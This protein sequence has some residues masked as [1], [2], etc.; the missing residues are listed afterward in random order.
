MAILPGQ[1]LEK[2]L[3]VIAKLRSPGGCPWD[4]EQTH[5]SLKPYLV[6]ESY[7]VLDAI[8]GQEP[9]VLKDELGDL[10]LQVVLHAQ[11]AQEKGDFTFAE[12]AENIREKMVRRHP[13]V[14]SDTKVDGV[15]QVWTNWEKIKKTEKDNHKKSILDSIPAS[16]PA[17]FRASKIQKKAARV[18]FDW[19]DEQGVIDKLQEEIN[20]LRAIKNQ[21]ELA[22]EFGDI[23]F[24]LVNFARK[25]DLDAEDTLRLATKKFEARFRKIEKIAQAAGKDLSEYSLTELDQLWQKAKK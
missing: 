8:D 18:G 9:A 16:L 25:K 23:L 24:T 4:K 22:D 14:F 10:L 21:K 15:N 20:E 1:E 7:E 12:V 3:A 17:L 11:I 2:L 19:P 5:E 6:E 13:H